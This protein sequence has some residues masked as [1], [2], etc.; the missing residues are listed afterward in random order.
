MKEKNTATYNT[1]KSEMH[2]IRQKNP[3][4]KSYKI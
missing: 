3:G 2:H 4:K 1:D